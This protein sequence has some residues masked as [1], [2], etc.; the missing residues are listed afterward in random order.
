MGTTTGVSQRKSRAEPE[1][2]RNAKQIQLDKANK[3]NYF[4]A[5][6][7]TQETRS[8]LSKIY[9]TFRRSRAKPGFILS[10]TNAT[11]WLA[12]YTFFRIAQ[13]QTPMIFIFP[14]H[15]ATSNPAAKWKREID[16]LLLSSLFGLSF[17]EIFS[18]G[19]RQ[20]TNIGNTR[21]GDEISFDMFTHPA[22][23][24]IPCLLCLKFVYAAAT[25]ACVSREW[26]LNSHMTCPSRGNNR[27]RLRRLERI[28]LFTKCNR[29]RL[30]LIRSLSGWDSRPW[31]IRWSELFLWCLMQV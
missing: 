17:L 8:L 20:D 11:A 15:K 30:A 7:T 16:P 14:A 25:L 22:L 4:S 24:F 12:H 31:T 6:W 5:C 19:R 27:I 3:K 28:N 29:S 9:S 21:E 2:P 10:H 23:A 18:D 1:E 26:K 13:R